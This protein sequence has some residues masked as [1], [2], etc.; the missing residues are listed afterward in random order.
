MVYRI[1][2]IFNIYVYIITKNSWAGIHVRWL[3]ADKTNILRTI[4][5]LVLGELS[6]FLVSSSL[7]REGML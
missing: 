2:L 6:L 4:S 5:V 1:V 3:K 7:G